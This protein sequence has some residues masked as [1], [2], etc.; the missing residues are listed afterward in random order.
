MTAPALGGWLGLAN[1][2]VIAIAFG[3]RAGTTEAFSL[4]LMFGALPGIVTGVSCGALAARTTGAPGWARL[5]TVIT[6]AIAVI[7]MMGQASGLDAYVPLCALPTLA[8]AVHLE[9]QTRRRALVPL[10]TARSV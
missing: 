8:A 1:V 9:R 6:P 4:V 2:V 3:V 7:A 10:A 5:A